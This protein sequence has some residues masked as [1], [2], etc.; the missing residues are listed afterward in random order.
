MSPTPWWLRA[1]SRAYNPEP[2]AA[3]VDAFVVG[4]GEE[5]IVD[6]VDAYQA[7]QEGGVRTSRPCSSG[8]RQSQV[9]TS[10][11]FTT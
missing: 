2:V 1:V 3:F 6:V 4:E 5:A 9:F 10:L 11:P 7:W 8:W